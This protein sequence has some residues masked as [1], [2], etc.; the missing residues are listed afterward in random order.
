MSPQSVVYC[1]IR[2]HTDCYV[3]VVFSSGGKHLVGFNTKLVHAAHVR[4]HVGAMPDKVKYVWLRLPDG[5]QAFTPENYEE[6][7]DE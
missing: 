5:R 1:V 7:V 3:E 2:A 6:D 4:G